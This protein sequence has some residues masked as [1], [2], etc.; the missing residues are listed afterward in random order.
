MTKEKR[1]FGE[2]FAYATSIYS[3]LLMK[4]IKLQENRVSYID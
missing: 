2:Q 4:E 1:F 3:F